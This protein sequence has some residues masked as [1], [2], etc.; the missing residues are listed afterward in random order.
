MNI[1]IT[2]TQMTRRSKVK[3]SKTRFE[4]FVRGMENKREREGKRQ[5]N[6]NVQWTY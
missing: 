5:G 1:A 6:G 4:R 3:G 2:V